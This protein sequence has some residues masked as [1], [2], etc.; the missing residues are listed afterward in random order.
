MMN[1]QWEEWNRTPSKWETAVAIGKLFD[2]LNT[3]A[4]TVQYTEVYQH[5]QYLWCACL[6]GSSDR[7][8]TD[9]IDEHFVSLLSIQ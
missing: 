5:V 7:L 6:A 4:V 9:N 8:R 1:M 2:K 3:A